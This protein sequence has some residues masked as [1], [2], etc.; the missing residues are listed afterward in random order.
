M[1]EASAPSI[2][3]LFHLTPHTS[4]LTPHSLRLTP[5]TSLITYYLLLKKIPP[6]ENTGGNN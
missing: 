3:R 6:D 1:A 5:Y 4:H 2:G